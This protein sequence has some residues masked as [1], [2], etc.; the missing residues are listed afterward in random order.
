MPASTVKGS[1]MTQLKPETPVRRETAIYY[2]G[3]PILVELHPG[4][5]TLREKGRRFK[6]AVD[7]RATLDLAYKIKHRADIDGRRKKK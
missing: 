1:Y 5:M 6:L 3:R 2:W 7:Y 4:Y